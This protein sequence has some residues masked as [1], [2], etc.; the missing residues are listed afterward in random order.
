[1]GKVI[2]IDKQLQLVKAVQANNET[3]LEQL[4][5]QN[6]FKTESYILKNNGTMPQAKDIYQEAFIT[7]WQNV[8]EGK[9]T[10]SNETALQGYLYQIAKFKWMDHLRSAHY[11]Q[12]GSLSDVFEL[13]D[14]STDM[15]HEMD[16]EQ[17]ERRAKGMQAFKKLGKECKELLEVFY[18]E[19]KSLREIAA[20]FNIGEASARNKKYRCIQKLRSLTGQQD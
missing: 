17:Q 16:L 15:P 19:K 12:T 8:K 11:K 13:K 6:Y 5:H 2:H 4:Y 1:M 3:V 20:Q 18:F 10:P 14:T 7:M 9:F